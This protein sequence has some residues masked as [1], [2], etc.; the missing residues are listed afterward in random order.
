MYLTYIY[1]S[2]FV[3]EGKDET[4][5]FDFYRDSK[6]DVSPDYIHNKALRNKGSIY[7]FCS[8]SH[9]DH[10][11]KGIL[12]WKEL[13]PDIIYIFSKEILD[14][15]KAKPED[16][17][18]LDKLDTYQDDRLGAKAYG[19]TDIGG[20]FLIKW[21]S[22]II[23]HAGDLNNWHWNE[24]STAEEIKKAE[25]DYHRE[26]NLLAEDVRHINLAMF[27]LDP[28]LGKDYMSGAEDFVKTVKVDIFSPMHFRKHFDDIPPFVP[29]ARKYGCEC[30]CWK[31]EGETKNIDI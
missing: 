7:V 16:A 17:V 1:N 25:S 23:F 5:I 4:L 28:R 21:E 24:E 14:S 27:P 31:Y 9:P 20:S 12:K 30:V 10:F 18:F 15:H 11:N 13:R 19:S 3:L 29:Y 6:G 22:K 2:G 8:H 26:L